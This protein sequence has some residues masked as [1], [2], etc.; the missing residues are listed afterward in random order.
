MFLVKNESAAPLRPD[1]PARPYPVRVLLHAA[2]HVPVHDV[3]QPGDIEPAA[4]DVR[5]HEARRLPGLEVAQRGFA[6]LLLELAVQARHLLA[7]PAQRLADEVYRLDPVREHQNARPR[8]PVVLAQLREVLQ[9]FAR[10][11]VLRAHVHGLLDIAHVVRA[12]LALA[13]RGDR[14]VGLIDLFPA[15]ADLSLASILTIAGPG[16]SHAFAT[17][18]TVLGNVALNRSVWRPGLEP[19]TPGVAGSLRS[20]SSSRSFRGSASRNASS[21]SANPSASMRSASSMTSM[22]ARAGAARRSPARRPACRACQPPA[23]PGRRAARAAPPAPPG[24]RRRTR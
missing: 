22:R 21:C 15:D 10:L 12:P 18:R 5:G 19:M 1:R 23:A 8:P 7:V 13:S 4:G 24:S 16:A 9:Q 14:D 6:L 11:L 2:G 17:A 20:V 3:L